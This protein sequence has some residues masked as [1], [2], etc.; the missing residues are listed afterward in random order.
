MILLSTRSVM[1][2]D[3]LDKK[4]CSSVVRV[5]TLK[6]ISSACCVDETLEFI[7]MLKSASFYDENY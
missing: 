4:K 3:S 7:S 2:L 5:R 1:Q 6:N